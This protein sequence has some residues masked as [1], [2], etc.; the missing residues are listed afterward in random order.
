[1]FPPISSIY[2]RL[3]S[4]MTVL[5]VVTVCFTAATILFSSLSLSNGI[6]LMLL[7]LLA[8]SNKLCMLSIRSG[9]YS[10]S[11]LSISGFVFA[12]STCCI[13]VCRLRI[14]SFHI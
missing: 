4:A 6:S 14:A 9:A 13:H 5:A 12:L 1:M 10:I 2:C 3:P 7:Y 11:G 8:L